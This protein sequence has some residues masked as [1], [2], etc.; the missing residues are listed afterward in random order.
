MD[1]FEIFVL[2][3]VNTAI[4]RNAP[5]P[6]PKP[7]VISLLEEGEEPWIPDV[8]S[9]EAVAG[10]VSAAGAGIRNARKSLQEGGVVKTQSGSISTEEIRRDVNVDQ[11][12][13]QAPLPAPKPMVISL[14]E[15]GEEPWIPDLGSPEAVVGDVSPAGAGIR[16]P[17]KGL[18]EGGVVKT[19]SGS[20]YMEQIRRD[21]HVDQEQ[22]Q[23]EHI[24]TQQGK[25][26]LKASGNPL[27]FSTAPI[28]APKPMVISL[29]EEEEEP[30]F[31]GVSS[32]EA[33]AK[34]V[35]P[36]AGIRNS[37]KGLQEGVV[38]N[39]QCGSIYMEEIR[40]DVHVDQ[41]QVHGE[42]N[43]IQQGKNLLK[44]SGNPLDISTEM[45]KHTDTA[46]QTGSFLKGSDDCTAI[47]VLFLGIYL[48]ALVG[49]GL[50]STAIACDQRL[51]TPMYFFL[52]NLALLDLGSISTT[53][54]KAM[55]NTLWD[56]RT[57]SYTA[58]PLPAPKP[59]VISL[60]EEGEEPWIPDLGSR[61]AVA[62]DVSPGLC[63]DLGYRLEELAQNGHLICWALLKLQCL[64]CSV[65]EVEFDFGELVK[66]AGACPCPQEPCVSLKDP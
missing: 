16:N 59:M 32:P 51:H 49:N 33:A 21:V 48:T 57:I 13:G 14:L 1:R 2:H 24:K 37:R 25:H 58:S 54:P 50:I 27:N 28:P 6:S 52:L 5:L 19:Q 31:P 20:I 46:L 22:G 39:R 47:K 40:R 64:D 36:G 12:Q 62:G 61:E 63:C 18:Q 60:L 9:P 44:A 10:D 11:E 56:T 35:S 15:E 38:V 17:R 34:D 41:E 23:G 30:C 66:P 29:L 55:A 45:S 42:Q 8:G 7:M 26:L 53:V 43:K 3:D 65:Q 4:P